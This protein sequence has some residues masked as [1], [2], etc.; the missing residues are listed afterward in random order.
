[1]LS[2]WQLWLFK[3]NHV[4]KFIAVVFRLLYVTTMDTKVS[5]WSVKC[6]EKADIWHTCWQMYHNGYNNNFLLFLEIMKLRVSY[7]LVLTYDTRVLGWT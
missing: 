7:T 2:F 5:V 6:E 1:M 3:N 4:L